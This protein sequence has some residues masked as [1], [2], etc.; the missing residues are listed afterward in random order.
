VA[1]LDWRAS[2]VTI[3]FGRL[4]A[5][6]G[7]PMGGASITGKGVWSET[8]DE[9]YFQI[10]APDDADL[11]VTTRDG[12]SFPLALPRAADSGEDIARIGDVECCDADRSIRLSGDGSGTGP[13]PAI[14]LGAL[15]LRGRADDKDTR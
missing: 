11:T 15:D 13:D 2:P 6:D 5:H 4:V 12:R 14:T 7:T 10:E 9:G 3:R 8:D 1:R